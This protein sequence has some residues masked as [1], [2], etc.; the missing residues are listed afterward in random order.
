MNTMELAGWVVYFGDGVLSLDNEKCG[1]WLFFFDINGYEFAAE[2]CQK[3][4]REGVVVE[5]KHTSAMVATL[6][7]TGVCCFYLNGDDMETHRRVIQFFLDNG[8]IKRTKTGKLYNISF[9]YDNQTRAGEYGEMFQPSIKLD[10]FLDL[11]TG[12]WKV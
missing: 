11:V 7:G 4:I 8:L 9:K 10:M 5:C 3:A 2:I 12:E 1:K 6:K